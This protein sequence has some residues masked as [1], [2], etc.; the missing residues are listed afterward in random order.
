MACKQ[1]DSCHGCQNPCTLPVTAMHAPR[2]GL[3]ILCSCPCLQAA[4]V[5]QAFASYEAQTGKRMHNETN[6]LPATVHITPVPGSPTA[7]VAVAQSPSMGPLPEPT[8]RA[9]APSAPNM[10]ASYS[11]HVALLPAAMAHAPVPSAVACGPAPEP[12]EENIS[13]ISACW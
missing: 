1:S 11:P 13:Y 6:A 5:R 8:A 2:V 4:D 10:A 3:F 12:R 7:T 9:Q